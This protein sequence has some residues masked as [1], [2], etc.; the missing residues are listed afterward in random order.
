LWKTEAFWKSM[1]DFHRLIESK[2][3]DHPGGGDVNPSLQTGQKGFR[4]THISEGVSWRAIPKKGSG[5]VAPWGGRR[6]LVREI[7]LRKQK[8]REKELAGEQ[9]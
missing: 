3:V 7:I 1:R 2:I 9:V 6:E 5:G 4:P 8:K